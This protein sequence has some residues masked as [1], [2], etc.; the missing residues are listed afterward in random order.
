MLAPGDREWVY[1]KAD[2]DQAK[3]VWAHDMG[4]LENRK[5]V[6]YF[7]DHSIWSLPIERDD[8]P[9]KLIPFP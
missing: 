9:V 2:I 8:A 1:N 6:N 7:K 3:V 4:Q 5:L